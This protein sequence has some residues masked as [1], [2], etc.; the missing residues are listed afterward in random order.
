MSFSFCILVS[1]TI[2]CCSGPSRHRGQPAIQTLLP[3]TNPFSNSTWTRC[4]PHEAYINTR[5]QEAVFEIWSTCTDGFLNCRISDQITWSTR[6]VRLRVDGYGF[7]EMNETYSKT[8][9]VFWN[10]KIWA[11]ALLQSSICSKMVKASTL[12]WHFKWI[13]LTTP[14]VR[15]AN[16][17]GLSVL[18]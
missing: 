6:V 17:P 7:S 5:M 11:F 9:L 1:T 14:A 13:E 8:V 16:F 15:L 10:T 12:S 4:W 18:C 3:T 2:Q